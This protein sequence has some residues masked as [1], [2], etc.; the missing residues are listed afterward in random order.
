MKNFTSSLI[1]A[2]SLCS[3][4]FMTGC[5]KPDDGPDPDSIT[6]STEDNIS[7][8]TDGGNAII[9][10]TSIPTTW[11]HEVIT[12]K[13][14]CEAIVDENTLLISV[15]ANPGDVERIATINI[16]AGTA[17]KEIIITQPSLG[18][19]PATT[20]QIPTSFDDGL[21]VKAL[22]GTR[23]AA[24]ICNEYIPSI[25]ANARVTVVYPVNSAGKAILTK[26]VLVKDGG[27]IVWNK[28]TNVCTYTAG[29]SSELT[30]VYCVNGEITTTAPENSTPATIV[31]NK[32]KDV[33]NNTY[34]IV[35]IGTQYWMAENLRVTKFRDGTSIPDGHIAWDNGDGIDWAE[36]DA[37]AT[38]APAYAHYIK[39]AWNAAEEYVPDPTVNQNE[40]NLL[41]GYYYNFSAIYNGLL[42]TTD[43]PESVIPS[44]D[45][46]TLAP[47]GWSVASSVEWNT[48]KSY[49]GDTPHE[50]IKTPNSQIALPLLQWMSDN[51]N[52][53]TGFSA[54]PCGLIF[55]ATDKY[56]FQN[57]GFSAFWWCAN[58][59]N[60]HWGHITSIIWS[61]FSP[62]KL[63]ISD[64]D[65]TDNEQSVEKG[66]PV[67]CIMN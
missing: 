20:I 56:G 46:Q 14:W 16:T 59:R 45:K 62:D 30:T 38:M 25:D 18:P 22:N 61:S 27:S 19:V 54:L 31:T 55:S 4:L 66:L 9:T 65:N 13:D 51:G 49:L 35:K 52:N 44:K 41:T 67:R 58:R 8:P 24:E 5:T 28:A 43:N 1:L 2:I 32:L 21:V 12:G 42:P 29:T 6:L 10:I 34:K 36:E 47:T 64:N 23:Q 63:D 3:L 48:L 17:K 39:Y 40:L 57:I 15:S 60:I 33:D 53:I 50:K 11:A 7:I 37:P 26:G